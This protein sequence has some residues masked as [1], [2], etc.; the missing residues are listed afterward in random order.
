MGI[1][2]RRE[3]EVMDLVSKGMLNKHIASELGVKE[4]TIK[5]H[6]V[7]VYDKFNVSNRTQ[8]TLVHLGYNSLL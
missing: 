4:E 7:S 8:A 6:L 3:T 2:T 1:L 5:N